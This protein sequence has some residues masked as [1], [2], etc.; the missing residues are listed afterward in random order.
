MDQLIQSY[1]PQLWSLFPQLP[2][3]V[4][5]ADTFRVTVLRWFGGFYGDVDVSLL[6]HP[7][8]WVHAADLKPWTDS[9][10][11]ATYGPLD[12]L[13]QG[14]IN[15]NTRSPTL[16][17]V[18]LDCP[19]T[20][21]DLMSQELPSAPTANG[22]VGAIF[23][24]ECD[25]NPRNNDH[26]RWGYTYPVQLTNWAMAAAP[27]HPA[28]G[29]YLSLLTRDIQGN[30]SRISSIDPLDLTGPPALTR[31]VMSYSTKA[32]GPDFNWNSLSGLSDPPGGRG[33]V[34]GGDIL[35]L[36]ITGFSPGRGWLHNM[37]SMPVTHD[38][39]RLLHLAQGSWRKL[40]TRVQMGKLCR[41]VL[42]RCKDWRKI[43]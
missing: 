11:G 9:S 19:S 18:P 10:T 14:S 6:E 4:E 23:G 35:V 12:S 24:I 17:Q 42:G 31:A 29:N 22:V 30:A 28:T 8:E 37:G 26:W 25:A 40:N 43:P 20:Y 41:T 1:E 2:Y 13:S 15:A 5:K 38:N 21:S 36:P 27:L 39:A 32:E 7:A 34:V 33:K 3:P 16:Y